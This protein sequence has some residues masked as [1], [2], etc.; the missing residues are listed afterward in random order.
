MTKQELA[1]KYNMSASALRTL[2]NVRFFEQLNAVGYDEKS[3]QAQH[4]APNV[5]K[6]FVE[7]W[8]PADIDKILN[9]VID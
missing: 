5:L 8:G 1:Q 9:D 7:L 3:K 6:K 4:I 2:M